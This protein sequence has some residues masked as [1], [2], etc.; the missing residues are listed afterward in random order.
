MK[1]IF[2]SALVGGFIGSGIYRWMAGPGW[3][4]SGNQV[5]DAAMLMMIIAGSILVVRIVFS[6]LSHSTG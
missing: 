4:V 2:S 5:G 6:R 3:T 1:I